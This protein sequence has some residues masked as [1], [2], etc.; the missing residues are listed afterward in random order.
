MTASLTATPATLIACPDCDLLQQEITLPAHG[1]ALCLRCEAPLFRVIPNSLDYT[2]ASL[3]AGLLFFV[4][5]NAYPLVELELK[6]NTVSSTLFGA[7]QSL[8]SQDLFSVATLVL[9]TTILAPA[10]EITAMLYLLIPLKFGKVVPALPLV[11]RFVER[12]RP[13]GMTEVF[14]L[15][16]LVAIVKLSTFARV[17]PGVALWSSGALMLSFS[18]A[19][20]FYNPRDVWR[21]VQLHAE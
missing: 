17:L 9:M 21:A 4:M 15:G 11:F 6:G 2:I 3:L 13:W 19:A 14:M 20:Y 7:V 8:A 1:E 18:A 12:I 10:C 16:T 5:A